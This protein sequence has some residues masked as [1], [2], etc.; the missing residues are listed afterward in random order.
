MRSLAVARKD[1]SSFFYSPL[2]VVIFVIFYLLTGVSFLLLIGSYAR[3][4]AQVVAGSMQ[5]VHN[6]RMTH[7]IFGSFFSNASIAMLF[8]IPLMTMKSFAEERNQQTSELLFTYPLSDSHI[9][10][11]KY[12]ALCWFMF[13][14]IAP[15]LGYVCL[16][17]YAGGLVE[18]NPIWASYL[19]LILL[20]SSFIA[21]GLFVS[22][23]TESPMISAMMTF[24]GLIMLWGLDWVGN[25]TDGRWSHVIRLLSP[26][27]HYREFTLGIIDF[28]HIVYFILFTLY[29][30][31]LSLRSVET[32]NWKG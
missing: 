2:G 4:S 5:D 23:L 10:W 17:Q 12:S 19:G 27:T 18:W 30:L 24:A 29:F 3:L 14:L 7:F 11:G 28:S 22:T 6:I 25:L 1:V 31:F 13:L 15:T 8:L 16:F 26:F 20:V 32:R 9:V 21:F